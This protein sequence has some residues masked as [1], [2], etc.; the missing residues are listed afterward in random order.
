M[1]LAI[2]LHC[3]Y[4]RFLLFQIIFSL[5]ETEVVFGPLNWLTV[6]TDEPPVVDTTQLPVMDTTVQ[7]DEVMVTT[8]EPEDLVRQPDVNQ[9]GPDVRES[10]DAPGIIDDVIDEVV[11]IIDEVEE[12]VE[13]ID[14]QT[15]PGWVSVLVISCSTLLFIGKPPYK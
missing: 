9:S 1:F 3:L 6:T 2:K 4:E 5:M 10:T 12:E 13:K 8:D 11:K 15:L 7:L 14:E